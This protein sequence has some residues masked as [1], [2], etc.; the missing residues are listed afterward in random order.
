MADQQTIS[1]YDQQVEKYAQTIEQQPS[2]KIL[3][4]FIARLNSNDLVLDLGCGPAQAS[5]IMRDN[6]LHVDPVDAS[7]EMVNI[8][9]ATYNIGAR[10]AR[11]AEIDTHDIY[12]GIWANFSLLHASKTEFPVI[13]G[14]LHQALK[15]NGV[16][17]LGMKLGSDACRDSLGRY[18]A[19]YSQEEL[20]ELLNNAQFDVDHLELG[21]G[22]GLAGDVEPWI[23]VIGKAR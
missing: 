4:R 15:P 3:S 20:C 5:A 10:Q 2:D 1:V 8:A 17:H 9:N 13:L 21:E 18:Y 12:H 14:Q 22:R 16:L 23:V 6:G 11:F 7:L 19:Y